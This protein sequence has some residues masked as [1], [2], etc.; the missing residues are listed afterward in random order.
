[1][2]HFATAFA[3]AGAAAMMALGTAIPTASAETTL[4]AA[5][6]F[7]IGSPPSRA[8]E[9]AV[10][11]INAKG[12]G[13]VQINIVGGAPAIG[14]F[15]E[16]TRKTARGIY[17]VVGCTDAYFGNVIAEA[18]AFRLSEFP[19]GELR[20]NGGLD[21]MSKLLS[22]KGIHYVGRHGDF[23]PFHLWL[24]KDHPISK[25]DLTGLNLRVAPIYTAFFRSLGATTQTAP[26][27]QIYQLMDKKTVQGY[28][29]PAAAWVPTWTEVTGYKVEPGFYRSPLHTMI[30]KRAWGKLDANSKKVINDVVMAMEKAVEPGSAALAAMLKKED[31]FR[32]SKGMKVITFTGDNAKKWVAAAKKAAWD[33]VLERSP[34]HGP[35]LQKLFTKPTS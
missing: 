18:P 15:L 11:D 28:G 7:P 22:D 4:K 26:L 17:D 30:N 20:K 35:K 32:A 27:P 5:S 24:H 2:K 9:A 34:E 3:S 13:V 14:N 21:Y 1:M 29:W 33:E 8:F 12:K 25:P 6:C 16:V 19:Y 10:K 31:A 23:G